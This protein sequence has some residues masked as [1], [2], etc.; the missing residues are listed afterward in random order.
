MN[1]TIDEFILVETQLRQFFAKHIH[2]SF[3]KART[4]M[5]Q[6]HALCVLSKKSPMS[7]KN[8]A[9]HFQMSLSAATQFI[10]RLAKLG[11]IKRTGDPSDKRVTQL[12]ITAKGK[13]ELATMQD[14]MRSKMKHIVSKIPE[15]DLKELIRIVKN[16][17]KSFKEDPIP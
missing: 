16:L 13:K 15:E 4:T 2:D 9:A 5:L 8:L 11:F 1:T 17:L 12:S 7:T 6:F 10:E 14:R 3:E